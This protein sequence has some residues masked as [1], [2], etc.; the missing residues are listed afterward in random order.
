[1]TARKLRAVAPACIALVWLAPKA[2]AADEPARA[3]QL[4][5][6]AR[7]LVEKGDYASAC[8]KLEESSKLEPAVGTQFNLADCYEH[9]GRTASAYTL[10][11]QVAAIARAAGKFERERSAKERAAK[12]ESNLARVH[13]TVEAPAP[14]IDV[15]LDDA[16]IEHGAA[17]GAVPVDPGKHV[18][19]ASAPSRTPWESELTALA[20]KTAEVVVPE[21]VDPTPRSR[22][23][24]PPPVTA[25]APPPRTQ[26]TIALVTGG[27]GVAGLVVGAVAGAVALSGRSDA[28][29]Q[30]PEATYHFRCPTQAG[31]D[32]WSS[33]ASAGTVS[34]IGFIAGG[35]LL[36]GATTLWLTAPRAQ[37][38][39]GA[40]GAGLRI[41]GTF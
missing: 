37:T 7:A 21:L 18:L 8:P 22:A 23:P 12:L 40:S 4:F 9:V 13:V 31:A 10:F 41:E 34:T 6:A 19:R 39:V 3:E 5:Q 11:R 1:M 15:R 38:R 24:A 25:D 33:A 30:C 17:A 2:A 16:P 28:E 20:G 29:R 26:R 36:A 35:I 14:G 32:A 27:V